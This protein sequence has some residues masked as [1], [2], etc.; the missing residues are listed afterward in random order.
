MTVK[1]E[2]RLQLPRTVPGLYYMLNK[3]PLCSIITSTQSAPF[4]K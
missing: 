3:S 4:Y 2:L 1:G